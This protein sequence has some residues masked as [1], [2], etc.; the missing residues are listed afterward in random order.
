[1]VYTSRPDAG[2]ARLAWDRFTVLHQANPLEVE[3]LPEEHA[4]RFRYLAATA[5]PADVKLSVT[6][7]E[8]LGGVDPKRLEEIK[9]TWEIVERTRE[10]IK[11]PYGWNVY[12]FFSIA[13]LNF[14]A[15]LWTGYR[16]L[17]KWSV[18]VDSAVYSDL[19][20]ALLF[21]IMA[22]VGLAG[23]HLANWWRR[24]NGR[25]FPLADAAPEVIFFILAGCIQH[26][27]DALG[28]VAVR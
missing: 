24:R 28:S 22:W 7:L 9:Q 20:W 25:P 14:L 11:E 23:R 10:K 1:M 15:I 6:G 13:S 21:L 2:D 19:R 26:L 17:H 5:S 16:L 27:L 8:A 12:I 3:L 18:N 4:W